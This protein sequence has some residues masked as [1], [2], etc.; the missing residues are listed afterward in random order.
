MLA[1]VLGTRPLEEQKLR[2]A[3]HLN[4]FYGSLD[5][6]ARNKAMASIKTAIRNENLTDEK[7]S[8]VAEEYMK[9]GGTP[10]GWKSAVNTAIAQT[11]TAGKEVFLHKLKDDNPLNFMID[12]LD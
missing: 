9:H 11:N 4:R 8:K 2:D 12:N 7:L 1:R 10:R 6:D 5:R 3:D